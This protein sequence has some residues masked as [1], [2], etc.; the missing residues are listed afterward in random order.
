MVVGPRIAPAL[1]I[2]RWSPIGGRLSFDRAGDAGVWFY[3]ESEVNTIAIAGLDLAMP[4]PIRRDMESTR[5]REA[6][7]IAR[8]CHSRSSMP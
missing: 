3:A 2:S 1:R 8:R 4:V 5:A 7:L 6:T